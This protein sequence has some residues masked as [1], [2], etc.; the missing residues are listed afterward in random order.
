MEFPSL[1]EYDYTSGDLRGISSNRTILLLNR[2]GSRFKKLTLFIDVASSTEDLKT[3]LNAISFLQ[4]LQLKFC[5]TS[6][7][8]MDDLHQLSSSPPT[9]A[10]SIPGFLP[11]L[12]SLSLSTSDLLCASTLE[13]LAH[14]FG[15]PHR[16]LLRVKIDAP[17]LESLGMMKHILYEIANSI[18]KE[19]YLHSSRRMGLS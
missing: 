19:Q 15:W 7:S 10:G 17:S 13:S 6:T 5:L 11:D 14:I 18:T 1:E 3:L 12:Q 9:L 8:V 4:H 16:K 2:S